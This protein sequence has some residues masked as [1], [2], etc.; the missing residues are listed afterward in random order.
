MTDRIPVT[1]LTGFLGA[2]KT[3]LLNR[4]L[5]QERGRRWGV[6][7][8][9]LGEI[10]IDGELIV[11]A[12]EELIELANGCVCC[13]IRGDLVRTV[14][15]LLARPGRL[16]GILVE[17]TG[18]AAPGPVAQSFLVD[19]VLQSRTRLDSITAVVDAAHVRLRLGDSPEAR[20]QIA[21]AD[22]I[23]LNKIDAVPAEALAGIESDV[24]RLNPFAP[25]HRATRAGVDLDRIQSRGGFDLDRIGTMLP[26]LPENP[27]HGAAGHVHDA[28]CGHD[29]RHTPSLAHEIAS[30][31]LSIEHT[32]DLAR[33]EHWLE[34]LVATRGADILRLKGIF[35]IAGEDRRYVAQAVHMLLEGDFQRP[36]HM[37]EERRSRLVLIGHRLERDTLQAALASC[38]A[39]D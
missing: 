14:Q 23:V 6:I 26:E 5:S 16:D 7:V 29:H 17:T 28:H 32:L 30:L 31:S 11:A 8:N 36:W 20:E 39:A 1:V 25:I 4:I 2:G 13:T 3:T 12:D 19:H 9:E 22:Q 37:D 34:T 15:G 35:H 38:V 33:L 27:P 21:F 24:R 18:I 10:G